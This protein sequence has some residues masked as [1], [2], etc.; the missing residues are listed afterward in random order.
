MHDLCTIK[1]L[2]ISRLRTLNQQQSAD[3]LIPTAPAKLNKRILAI[4]YLHSVQNSCLFSLNVK[5][6]SCNF[7]KYYNKATRTIQFNY[8]ISLTAPVVTI[9]CTTQKYFVKYFCFAT[10]FQTGFTTSCC[11]HGAVQHNFSHYLSQ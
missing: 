11:A 2:E 3:D 7:A 5:L 9:V 6:Y 4:I 1:A 10:T 8:K